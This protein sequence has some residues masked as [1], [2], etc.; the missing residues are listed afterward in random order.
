MVVDS[1][2][3]V[4]IQVGTSDLIVASATMTNQSHQEHAASKLSLQLSNSPWPLELDTTSVL[5]NKAYIIFEKINH[6]KF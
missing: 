2:M 1:S 5:I 3:C 6:A 4:Y